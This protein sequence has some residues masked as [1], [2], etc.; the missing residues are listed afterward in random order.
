MT[1]ST[2]PYGF[3]L[4]FCAIE[5]AGSAHPVESV[6]RGVE[7]VDRIL[8]NRGARTGDL[9]LLDELATPWLTDAAGRTGA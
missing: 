2:W 1:P 9:A 4:E 7:L 5:S 8:A 6:P 3:A